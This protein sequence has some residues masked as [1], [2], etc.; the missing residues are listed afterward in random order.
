MAET[1]ERIALVLSGG[2]ARAAYQ[3]GVIKAI[4]ELLPEFKASPFSIICGVSAGAIN[5]TVM[6][7][8][9]SRFK[10]GAKRL[11]HVWA[12]FHSGQIYRSDFL[13]MTA[14]SLRWLAS[15]ARRRHPDTPS[16]SMLDNNPLRELL[17][18][19]VPF[20]EIAKS[21]NK[22]DLYAVSVTCSG[23]N[24]GE[25]ISFFEGHEEIDG[26]HRYRR[27][28]AR[29]RIQLQHLMASSAIPLVFPAV[30]INREYFGDGSVRFM[31]PISPALHLG[32][33]K[34]LIVGVDPV[35][36]VDKSRQAAKG[37]PTVAEIAGHVMD[38]VFLDSL[39]SDMERLKR[40]NNTLSKIPEQ[41]RIDNNI[42]LK[43]I[44]TLVI[45]PSRDLSELSGKHSRSLP[46]V[47]RFFFRRIGITGKTGS[48]ILSYLLFESSFTKELIQ[49]G[50]QDAMHQK[51]E[52]RG[53]FGLKDQ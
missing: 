48:T 4:A 47:V 2:G 9:A 11:E 33:T 51:A 39:D 30:K 6:A 40:I 10:I 36:D 49:L 35:R 38:S 27:S 12:N 42:N 28:G 25:S 43:P 3:V 23:Y 1:Q 8:S 52:I 16:P 15:L 24:S 5:A 26:W 34:V 18:T 20:N 7:C 50:Y 32:A 45:A 41:V 37:Y 19:V 44:D 22:G 21:I 14:N 31:A 17:K 29:T 46:R 53:F 13:G